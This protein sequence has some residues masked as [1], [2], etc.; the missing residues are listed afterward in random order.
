MALSSEVDAM[1]RALAEADAVGVRTLPNPR[2]GCVVLAPDGTELSR[3]VHRGAGT[4][5]AEVDALSRAGE[6]ARGATVVVTLEPCAHTGRT[7]P[8]TEAL[9]AAGVARVVYAQADPNPV[10]GGGAER[11]QEG[12]IDVE[13]GVLAEESAAM[14]A[15]WTH[16]VVEGRPFVTWK[17][18]ATLDGR[19]AAIDGTSRW[20]TCPEARRDVQQLRAEADAIAAGTGT[21][22]ADDPRLTVRDINDDPVDYEQQ[23]LRVVVG[24]SDLPSTLRIWNDEAPTIQIRS[25]SPKDVLLA[26][27]AEGIRHVWLEGGPRIAGAFVDAGLI[28][29]IVGYVS[30]LVLGAGRSAAHSSVTTLADAKPFCFTDVRRIGA[31]VRVTAAPTGRS[32]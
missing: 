27:D 6:G 18:G 30:P 14:N 4:A 2:V 19:V 17:Y 9:L 24:C 25:R 8:C 20:I 23:P 12:G 29:R 7:G 32:R 11:L 31:D 10:A 15:V 3:G 1:G 21:V 13:G 28:D 22:L 26:L 16:S 5:H